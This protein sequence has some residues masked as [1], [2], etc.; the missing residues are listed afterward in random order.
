MSLHPPGSLGRAVTDLEDAITDAYSAIPI[1]GPL[2]ARR[3][4]QRL[5][6]ARTR[7]ALRIADQVARTDPDLAARMVASIDMAGDEP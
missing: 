7:D 3:A 4:R 1:A 5:R 6:R 2:L